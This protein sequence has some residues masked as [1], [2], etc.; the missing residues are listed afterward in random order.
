MKESLYEYHN[1]EKC[2][3]EGKCVWSYVHKSFEQREIECLECD[4]NGP[5]VY[6]VCRNF[7]KFVPKRN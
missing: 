1:R 4:G 2:S 5:K 3:V 7:I 6:S